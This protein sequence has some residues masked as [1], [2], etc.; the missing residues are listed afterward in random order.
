MCI[1]L[2]VSKCLK[3]SNFWHAAIFD[4]ISYFIVKFEYNNIMIFYIDIDD[5][6]D[7][8]QNQC[9]STIHYDIYVE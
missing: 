5:T 6:Y 3:I 9:I 1:A 8:Y 7:T 2:I 4:T